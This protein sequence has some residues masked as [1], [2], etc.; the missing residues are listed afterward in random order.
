[1]SITEI[2]NEL[3]LENGSNYKLDVLRKHKD[4]KLLQKVLK[5]A[6]DGCM[7]TYGITMKNIPE[8]IPEGSED[9]EWALE[10]LEARFV[11]REY[12]GN[13]AI[14]ELHFMLE[15][16]QPDDAEIVV[17]II[18]RD[19]KIRLGRTQINKVWKGLISKSLYMRCGIYTEDSTDKETGKLI[20]GTVR[21]INPEGS[22]IQLKADGTYRETVCDGA[23]EFYSRSNEEYDYPEFAEAFSVI[24]EGRFHG[25]MTV[26][27]DDD[28]LAKIL[29]K[30]EKADKKNGT[31]NVE[32]IL[33]DYKAA[34][35]KNED[36]ILPRSIGNGLLKSGDVPMDNIHYDLWDYITPD[37]YQ[38]AGQKDRKNPCTVHY[39]DRFKNLQEIVKVIN[40]PRIQVIESHRVDSV[41]EALQ[42]VSRWMNDGLEGGIWK[43]KEAVL[44]D[45][46]SKQQLKLKL[47]INIDVRFVEFLP[48]NPGSKNEVYFSAVTF[49]TDDGEIK[50]QIGVTTMPETMRDWFHENRDKVKGAVAAIICN[51]ITQARNKTTHALSHPRFDEIR[52][53]KETTDTL[54]R[55]LENKASAMMLTDYINKNS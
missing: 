28:L 46:N 55:A 54:E 5:M 40:H 43:D 21:N 33:K 23:T 25:E 20:K 26:H 19:L 36:Y 38:I 52:T 37:E 49:E 7:Y 35:E 10:M 34:Q 14:E 42:H 45:G 50:G 53:D 4:N 17:K 47:E 44:K 1:M 11:T 2:L 39:E 6:L 24:E 16:L 13:K 27:L 48:G 29:P 22:F 8:Y 9:L 12:T 15:N 41:G 32:T 31:K 3:N 30:L 18:N 51:D